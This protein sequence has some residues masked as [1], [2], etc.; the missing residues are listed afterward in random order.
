MSELISQYA[1][2]YINMGEDTEERQNYL[3][4]ACTAWNIANLD[5]KHREGAIR[6]VVEGY[7]RMNPGSNDVEN[8]EHDLR[9][10]IEKKVEMFPEIK[11]VIIDAMIEPISETKYQINIASSDDKELLKEIFRK[12]C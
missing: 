1:S 4:G 9:I 6:H 2:D 3:N 10:L 7:K 11:K 8:F 12:A 5:E